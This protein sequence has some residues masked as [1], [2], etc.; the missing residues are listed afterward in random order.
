M[1]FFTTLRVFLS[2]Y[3][4]SSSLAQCLG[5]AA[6]GVG[7]YSIVKSETYSFVTGNDVASGAGVLIAVGA[8]I[9]I[10]GGIGVLGAIFRWRPLLV[11]V[12]FNIIIIL[13]SRAGAR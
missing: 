12:S 9:F 10:V 6:V 7:S 3:S 4:A 11:I 1:S 13:M 5:L 8:V 2:P